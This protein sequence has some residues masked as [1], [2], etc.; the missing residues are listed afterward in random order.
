MA[1]ED[2]MQEYRELYSS[3]K[4]EAESRKTELGSQI[5]DAAVNVMS[6]QIE[7]SNKYRVPHSYN[8]KLP[9]RGI[10][11]KT[12]MIF[13]DRI[14]FTC[15]D[16]YNINTEYIN[17]DMWFST[18]INF[19]EHEYTIACMTHALQQNGEMIENH[20]KVIEY[21]QRAIHLLKYE[22]EQIEKARDQFITDLKE[23]KN[24]LLGD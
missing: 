14:S 19:N 21:H 18:I 23:N 3:M 4:P 24:D 16:L 5:L 7:I 12:M 11:A 20:N 1:I 8:S 9:S 17:V 6:K 10:Y 22:T 15:V 13:Y 2:I